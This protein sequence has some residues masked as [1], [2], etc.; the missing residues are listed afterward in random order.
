MTD[1][2]PGEHLGDADLGGLSAYISEV[3]AG[4]AKFSVAGAA[5]AMGVSRAY[6]YRMMSLSSIPSEEFEEVLDE[7]HSTLT[8]LADSVKRR[9]GK[10]QVYEECCPHCG[11]PLRTR[12]R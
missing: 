3:Q 12:F 4:A 2:P 1:C 8:G 9:S 7:G 10:A 5:R 6:V 11:E